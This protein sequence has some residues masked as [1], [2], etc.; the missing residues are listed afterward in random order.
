MESFLVSLML[1]PCSVVSWCLIGLTSKGSPLIRSIMLTWLGIIFL[2]EFV[3]DWRHKHVTIWIG[4]P[5]CSIWVNCLYYKWP[6]HLGQNLPLDLCVMTIGRLTT[7]T[8]TPFLKISL[9]PF[10]WRPL[11][12]ELGTTQCDVEPVIASHPALSVLEDVND[13]YLL[14]SSW[15]TE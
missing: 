5:I 8:K 3:I 9:W 7:K 2:Q 4:Q 6:S 15:L 14:L 10:Y 1:T 12:F 11:R 13:H